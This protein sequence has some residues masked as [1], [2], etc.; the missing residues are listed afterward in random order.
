[1]MI[2]SPVITLK[3]G[4][5]PLSGKPA[6]GVL[7]GSLLVFSGLAIL[8]LAAVRQGECANRISPLRLRSGLHL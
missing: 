6:R 5:T 3:E 2:L 4:S 7:V 8:A 1:M